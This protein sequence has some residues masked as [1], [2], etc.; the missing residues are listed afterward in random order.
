MVLGGFGLSRVRG[1]EHSIYQPNAYDKH[2]LGTYCWAHFQVQGN[3]SLEQGSGTVRLRPGDIGLYTTSRPFSLTQSGESFILRIPQRSLLLPMSPTQTVDALMGTALPRERPLV[4]I[5][6]AAAL[7]LSTSMEHLVGSVGARMV[8]GAVDMLAAIMAENSMLTTGS[9]RSTQLASVLDY[10]EQHLSRA[11]L[12]LPRIASANFMS[13]RTLHV[14]FEDHE[15]TAADWVRTRRLQ[16]CRRDL[17]D[18]ELA[19]LRIA[20]I[21]ARWGFTDP[22]HFSRI[23]AGRYG[24]PP[25]AFRSTAMAD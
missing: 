7:R 20:E 9:R 4:P 21:A 5:I 15:T 16:N 19:D 6:H 24:L 14:L 23:F 12:T 17:A 25:R 3:S 18:S 8:R 1:S 11:D 10:I 22:A 13:V 2:H